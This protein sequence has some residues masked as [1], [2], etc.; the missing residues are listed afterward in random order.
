MEFPGSP[1][2]AYIILLNFD[3]VSK[4]QLEIDK[5]MLFLI[6]PLLDLSTKSGYMGSPVTWRRFRAT[7]RPRVPQLWLQYFTLTTALSELPEV[8]RYLYHQFLQV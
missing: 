4:I 1:Y 7:P 5:H 6:I 8:T 3:L 2:K